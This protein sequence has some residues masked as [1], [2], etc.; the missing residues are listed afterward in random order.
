LCVMGTYPR[1]NGS[2]DVVKAESFTC[3]PDGTPDP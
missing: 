3:V 1:Y 2:G